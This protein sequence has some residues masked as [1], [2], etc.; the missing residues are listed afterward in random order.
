MAR[1]IP[2]PTATGIIQVNI[3]QI[4]VVEPTAGGA[5]IRFDGDH[6]VLVTS[7]PEDVAKAANRA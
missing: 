7:T 6:S 1:F 4:R 5:I 2:L 3:D